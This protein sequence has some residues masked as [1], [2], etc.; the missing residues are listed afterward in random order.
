MVQVTHLG[1]K[2]FYME[3]F[4]IAT[5]RC[6]DDDHP[7]SY[8]LRAHTR[9]LI[10]NNRVGRDL[11]IAP[12]GNVD[13]LL[14]GEIGES[15]AL[16]RL[17]AINTHFIN[18]N[19]VN[20]IKAR[21]V[22]KDRLPYY[23]YRDDG[24]LVWDAIWKFT[25]EYVGVTYASDKEIQE[26]KELQRWCQELADPNQG[27]VNGMKSKVGTA[28]ELVEVLTTLI[29]ISGPGHCAGVISCTYDLI[30]PYHTYAW[31]PFM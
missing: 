26:D 17:G 6:L 4:A 25:S 3:A 27:T 10:A 11:L 14:A 29:F 15:V 9:F 23:P 22:T 20:D 2:H 8:I 7:L 12:G 1:Q 31:M 18:D 5:R 28:E 24:Q 21:N 13:L 30:T 19:F 16:A